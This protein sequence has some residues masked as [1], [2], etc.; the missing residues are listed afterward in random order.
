M[1]SFCIT[2]IY[3]FFPIYSIKH[4]KTWFKITLGTNNLFKDVG[5]TYVSKEQG[6]GEE[7][8]D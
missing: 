3:I 6:E 8:E 7:K 4:K 5:S 1:W 2:N